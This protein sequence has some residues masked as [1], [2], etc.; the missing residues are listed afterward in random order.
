LKPEIKDPSLSLQQFLFTDSGKKGLVLF[1]KI[2]NLQRLA[3]PVQGRLDLL[4]QTLEQGVE[5]FDLVLSPIEEAEDT[6]DDIVTTMKPIIMILKLAKFDKYV[7][8]ILRVTK[9]D[10]MVKTT[11]KRMDNGGD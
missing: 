9:F 8:K 1:D 10:R 7:F 11:K 2:Q 6:L 4:S 3:L 5:K